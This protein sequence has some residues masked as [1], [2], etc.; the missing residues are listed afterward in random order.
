M[1]LDLVFSQLLEAVDTRRIVG[2]MQCAH[3]L[4]HGACPLR[5]LDCLQIYLESSKRREVYWVQMTQVSIRLPC[6]PEP[7]R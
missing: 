5:H 6:G 4:S 2:H 7:H 3:S 1:A